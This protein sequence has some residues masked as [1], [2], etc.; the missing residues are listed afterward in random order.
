MTD[1]SKTA[2]KHF[3]SSVERKSSTHSY[4]SFR[5][6]KLLEMDEVRSEDLNLYNCASTASARAVF[7]WSNLH[8]T[9]QCLCN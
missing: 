7:M 9:R 5:A 4:K 8:Y 6:T 2:S 1:L 3:A